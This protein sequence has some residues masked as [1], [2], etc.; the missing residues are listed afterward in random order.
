LRVL[1]HDPQVDFWGNLDMSAMSLLIAAIVLLGLAALKGV[2]P[3]DQ[4]IRAFIWL[5][6]R[7]AAVMLT[8]ART[9]DS[10]YFALRREYRRTVTQI[11]HERAAFQRV[12]EANIPADVRIQS[13]RALGMLP[14]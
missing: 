11:D 14:Q 9:T 7:T 12:E 2:N 4:G 10:A 3:F 1:P 5:L 8:V 13:S 6:Y